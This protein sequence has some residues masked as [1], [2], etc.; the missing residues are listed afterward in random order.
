MFICHGLGVAANLTGEHTSNIG[1]GIDLDKVMFAMRLRYTYSPE[2][3]VDKR[4]R[5][6]VFGEGLFGGIHGFNNT[7]PSSIGTRGSTSSFAM[8][9]GGGLSQGAAVP[10]R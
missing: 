6:A 9:S 7:F 2:L 1:A 8:H 3:P 5:V 4:H 10:F